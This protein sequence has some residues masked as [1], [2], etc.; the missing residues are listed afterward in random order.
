MPFIKFLFIETSSWLKMFL[1]PETSELELFGSLSFAWGF[2]AINVL[3]SH[4]HAH[5][6]VRLKVIAVP[7]V[8]LYVASHVLPMFLFWVGL[9]S[10]IWFIIALS[11]DLRDYSARHDASERFSVF[12][13]TQARGRAQ[14]TASPAST[15]TKW[16]PPACTPDIIYHDPEC[17][18]CQ[19]DYAGTDEKFTLLCGHEFHTGCVRQWFEVS[20]RCPLCRRS[21]DP[22]DATAFTAIF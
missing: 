8:V 7:L 6:F 17:A 13:E 2:Y 9:L 1:S 12:R 11:T 15:T 21:A 18:V 3:L 19:E 10:V 22:C 16:M 4:F 5:R 20:H 14:P